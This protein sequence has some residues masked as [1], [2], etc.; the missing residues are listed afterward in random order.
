VKTYPYCAAMLIVSSSPALAAVP[1][2]DPPLAGK[3]FNL[4]T[5]A[6]SVDGEYLSYS[7]TYGSRRIV[8]ANT[9]M[10]WAKTD[11]SLTLS[12]GQ[13]KAGGDNFKGTRLRATLVHKWTERLSTR[14]TAGIASDKPIFV[15]RELV[16]E[17]SYKP[18]PQTVL[19]VGGRYSRYFGG[20]D[21]ISWSV[22]AAQYFR[23]GM[24]GYRY[25]S[26]DVQHIGHTSGHL[27]NLKVSD[28]FGSNQL[29]LGHGT[30]L[31]DAIWLASPEKGKFTSV[32]LRRVQPIGGGVSVM[33]GANKAWYDTGSTKFDSKGVRLGLTFAD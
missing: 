6:A 15:T 26:Y 8:N 30:A 19:T 33:I 18:M 9:T 12:Q 17:A 25:S 16:Q 20:V 14:T 4:K 23:G 29:W 5:I 31:H 3:P 10:G 27:V 2:A 22:G 24:M 32:E 21:A 7:D 1:V 11:L 13:R 28:R